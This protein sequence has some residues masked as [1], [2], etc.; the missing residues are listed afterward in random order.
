MHYWYY[1]FKAWVPNP[2]SCDCL[3]AGLLQ[4]ANRQQEEADADPTQDDHAWD[5]STGHW[6][7][8]LGGVTRG[9][10]MERWNKGRNLK[11]SDFFLDLNSS[12]SWFVCLF[13]FWTFVLSPKLSVST[14]VCCPYSSP[15]PMLHSH[16][17]GMDQVDGSHPFSIESGRSRCAA[18]HRYSWASWGTSC[19]VWIYIIATRPHQQVIFP[20][21][22][23]QNT[24]L[25][26]NC[27][28]VWQCWSNITQDSVTALRIS[29][30]N[31]FRNILVHC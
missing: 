26:S 15:G 22:C 28:T 14:S 2:W 8:Q 23:S 27:Q 18:H 30:Q 1:L 6:V 16:Q 20:A 29:H 9:C 11:Q 21:Q 19:S 5:Q 13:S 12:T 10:W 7:Q 25:R 24:E 17:I 4:E 31:V 3:E